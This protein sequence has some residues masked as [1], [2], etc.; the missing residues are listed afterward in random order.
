M[1]DPLA[2]LKRRAAQIADINGVAGL[3]LWDQNTMMPPGGSDAR[4]DQ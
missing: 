4:A 2:D 1:T 3:L